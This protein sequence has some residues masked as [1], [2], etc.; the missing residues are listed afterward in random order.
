MKVIPQPPK[1]AG[2]WERDYTCRECRSVLRVDVC[3]LYARNTAMAYAGE[4]WDP[5]LFYKCCVC[6]SENDVTRKV[7][8]GIEHDLFE[9]LYARR[10]GGK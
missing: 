3:D 9:K 10:K 5:R 1:T 2:K 8:H 7:P 4:T 6:K